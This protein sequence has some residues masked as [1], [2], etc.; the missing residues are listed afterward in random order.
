MTDPV[1][2]VALDTHPLSVTRAGVARY[3]RGLQT[4][5]L[6]LDQKIQITPITWPVENFSYVQPVRALKTIWRELVWAPYVAP[7]LLR[8]MNVQVV[9]HTAGPLLPFISPLRQVVTL[10]D[11][12]L[13]RGPR[14]FRTWQ[15]AA[16]LRRLRRLAQADW[17]ICVS[18]FTA[19]EAM[20][21][22]GLPAAKIAVVHHGITLAAEE[23]LL[24]DLPAEF[25]LFVGSLEPGKNLSFLKSLWMNAGVCLPPL[26]I[27]GDRWAGVGDEG[28]VP[29]SWIYLGHQ[30]DEVLLALYRRAQALLFPSLYEGFGFPVVEAMA[31]GCPVICAPRASLPE[32]ATGA[33]NLVELESSLWL[34]AMRGLEAER[35]NW[36]QRG[37]ARAREFS[38][39]KCAR[40][41]QQI[42]RAAAGE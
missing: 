40:E 1:L 35:E 28:V 24:A 5:F 33:V 26:V 19:D 27:V 41:T 31:A 11:L 29:A 36:Q 15:R 8:S 22:L 17:V 3:V 14:R 7:A 13:I 9:H 38:W 18:K 10:H 42:Y 34:T 21:L 4:G 12:A 37:L 6:H 32:I 20:N 30:S 2:R 39:E 16:G 23:N 25:Y